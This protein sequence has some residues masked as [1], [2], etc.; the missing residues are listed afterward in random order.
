MTTTMTRKTRLAIIFGAIAVAVGIGITLVMANNQTLTGI[1]QLGAS[2]D[3]ENNNILFN[4]PFAY[5]VKYPTTLVVGEEGLF[6]G[7]GTSGKEPYKFEWKFSDG[8]TLT[9]Q[10]ITRSFNSSGTYYFDL[11]VTDADGKQVKGENMSFNVTQ[12]ISNE[13]EVTSNVTPRLM[14]HN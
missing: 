9:G 7:S 2:Q 6:N 10:K 14:P 8:A 11:A 3:D 4:R 1:F 5:M 12:E 13:D